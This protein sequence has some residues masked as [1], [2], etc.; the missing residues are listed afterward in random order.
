MTGNVVIV[1]GGQAAVSA[2]ATL[3]AEGFA[4]RVVLVSAE[5]VAPY[6][7]PP[8]SKKYLKGEMALDRLFLKPERF[9][10]EQAIDLR[11]GT[12]ARALDRRAARVET[13]GEA[14]PYDALIL[15]TG[16]HPRRLPEAMGGS[17][18]GVHAVRGVADIDALAPAV[19]PGARALVV[20]G[21]YIGLEAAA[22]A[23]E[24]GLAVTLVERAPRLLA[25]VAAPETADWFR[26][27]HAGRGV[28]LREG[29]ALERIE[30]D[31]EG[32]V[33]VI[34]GEALPFD[35]AV[36]GIGIA[37]ETALAEGAG[38]DVDEGVIVD[39]A[40]RTSDPAILAAGDCTAFPWTMPDGSVRRIRLE[41]V[42]NAID[43]GAQA[44]RAILGPVEDYAP[45]PWFWSDQ[46]DARLQIAGLNLGADARVARPG[47][48]PGGRSVWYF[49]GE[50]LIAVDAMNDPRAY[51]QGKRWL[52][53]GEAPDRAGFEALAAG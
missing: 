52:E 33:A 23:V 38:L 11:L 22:V 7:R 2:A 32:L 34:D 9:Y 41:S 43:Q 53:R 37:P 26:D 28:A 19:R 1:G 48:R 13:D 14:I 8:L 40:C 51:M 36:V 35:L 16:S 31:G 27:L 30:R 29:A 4:G 24:R 42:Q 21:G 17:L 15:A 47:S 12:P 25:R 39:G 3:R 6:Q 5:P 10:V 49:A 45:V 18:P 44:A 50:R 20:G 46:Y